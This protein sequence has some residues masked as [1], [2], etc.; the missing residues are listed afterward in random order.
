MAS[1]KD[2][3]NGHL[4]LFFV[5]TSHLSLSVAKSTV[6]FS[7]DLYYRPLSHACRDTTVPSSSSDDFPPPSHRSHNPIAPLFLLVLLT[8]PLQVPQNRCTIFSTTCASCLCLTSTTPPLTHKFSRCLC[9]PPLS[10]QHCA[11]TP[12]CHLFPSSV[13][14]FLSYQYHG[15]IVPSFFLGTRACNL[16][17]YQYCYETQTNQFFPF[18]FFFFFFF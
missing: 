3:T 12:L 15:T 1:A 7:V 2:I 4:R 8:S 11:K 6:L 17:L 5:C 16:P 9:L 13:L 10:D 14:P 18:F